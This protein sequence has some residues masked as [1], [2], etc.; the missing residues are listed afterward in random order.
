MAGFGS[1]PGTN[2][3]IGTWNHGFEK[4]A[5]QMGVRLAGG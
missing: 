3:T 4:D 2:E 5:D 1:T